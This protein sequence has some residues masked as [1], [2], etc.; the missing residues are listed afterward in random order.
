MNHLFWRHCCGAFFLHPESSQKLGR[1]MANIG[2]SETVLYFRFQS[3]ERYR[4]VHR[5]RHQTCERAAGTCQ[6]KEG[7]CIC[8]NLGSHEVTSSWV[9]RCAQG[10]LWPMDSCTLPHL[11]K[12]S[13]FE[14]A[15]LKDHHTQS[16]WKPILSLQE[17]SGKFHAASHTSCQGLACARAAEPLLG[18]LSLPSSTA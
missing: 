3:L 14:P 8:G 2:Q 1:D 9:K 4:D 10:T 11:L 7:A 6:G 13:A 15:H 5:Q 17:A 16:I 18:E 12:G